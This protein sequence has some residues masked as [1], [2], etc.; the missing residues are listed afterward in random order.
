MNRSVLVFIVLLLVS[1]VRATAGHRDSTRV[2]LNRYS[3]S[4]GTGWTHYINT[5]D[6]AADEAR[7]NSAGLSLKFFWEPEHRLS[8]GLETGWYRL[9][10]IKGEGGGKITM[11]AI[12]LLLNIRMRIVSH[13]YLGTGAG[14]AILRNDIKGIDK[15]LSNK[16][17]SLSNYQFSATYLYPLS[18][19]WY[20][21]G[22]A[23]TYLFGKASDWI[24]TLQAMCA[25]KL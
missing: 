23:K 3:L 5:L 9:Y 17:L 16:V 14:L 12:P 1:G 6:I 4:V 21:G 18:D 24:Y 15:D 13:L 2:S 25:I 8:L 10:A 11:T 22:E 20:I 19:R 7:T